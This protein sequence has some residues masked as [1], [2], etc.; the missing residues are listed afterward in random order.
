MSKHY[1]VPEKGIQVLKQYLGSKPYN[2]VSQ[3]IQLLDKC[4]PVEIK[5]Q[6]E[7]ELDEKEVPEKITDAEAVK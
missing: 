3:L 4:P 6:E 7:A 2:E 1:V 5:E